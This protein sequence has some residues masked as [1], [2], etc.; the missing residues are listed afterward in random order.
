M[1]VLVV[2]QNDAD[3]RWV[4][5]ILFERGVDQIF[6]CT[7][8]TDAVQ[9]LADGDYN[10]L[11]TEVYLPVLNGFDLKKLLDSFGYKL[12]IA[13]FSDKISETTIKEAEDAGVSHVFQLDNLD[14]KL[15]QLIE[16]LSIQA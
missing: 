10:L 13:F 14:L 4:K 5:N 1:K 8:S 11:L 15:P 16:K 9:M 3:V 12:P 2:S 7:N 6:S